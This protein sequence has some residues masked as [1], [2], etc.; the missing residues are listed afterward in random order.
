MRAK[1]PLVNPVTIAR[2]EF[3]TGMGGRTEEPHIGGNYCPVRRCPGS[4]WVGGEALHCPAGRGEKC[5]H[6]KH[7]AEVEAKIEARRL[8]REPG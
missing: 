1:R 4:E 2:L 3:E 6:L 7:W 8:A 5:P